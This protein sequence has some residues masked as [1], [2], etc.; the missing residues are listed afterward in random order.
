M[1]TIH[2]FT[3]FLF[4]ID[5]QTNAARLSLFNFLRNFFDGATELNEEIINR[6]IRRSLAFQYW[7]ERKKELSREIFFITE[8]F[9]TRLR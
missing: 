9:N 5:P 7:Q 8:S 3:Q 2:H 1:A 4:S 6:F